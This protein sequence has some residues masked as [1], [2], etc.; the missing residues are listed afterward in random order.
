MYI[1]DTFYWYNHLRVR[2]LAETYM[3]RIMIH[4]GFLTAENGLCRIPFQ[5]KSIHMLKQFHIQ[6]ENPEALESLLNDT[7]A[8]FT[9]IYKKGTLS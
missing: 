2:V 6:L 1:D 7:N 4:I 8:A 3:H 5:A 9:K